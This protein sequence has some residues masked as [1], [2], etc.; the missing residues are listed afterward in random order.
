M[1][2]WRRGGGAVPLLLLLFLPCALA[3]VAEEEVA[4]VVYRHKGGGLLSAVMSSII[5][6]LPP[7]PPQGRPLINGTALMRTVHLDGAYQADVALVLPSFTRIVLSEGSTVTPTLALGGEPEFPR[8]NMATALVLAS[9][10]R[11]VGA[12]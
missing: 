1:G 7:L 12:C 3:A 9:G 5:H 6:K 10:Q 2:L 4:A 11:M 8:G